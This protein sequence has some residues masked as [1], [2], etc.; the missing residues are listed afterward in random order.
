M[1]LDP[2]DEQLL[3]EALHLWEERSRKG[4]AIDPADLVPER[5]DLVEELSRRIEEVSMFNDMFG[6][7]IS[8]GIRE[9]EGTRIGPYRL[10]ENLG[11]G[12]FGVVFMADQE[13]PIRR[14]VAL[15]ILKDELNSTEV[16]ARFEAERHALALMEH[17]NIA[18]V[19]DAGATASGR[20]YFVM[21]LVK[22]IAIT[23]YCDLN[24]LTP[25]QRLELFVPVCQAIQHAHQKGVIHRD[26]KPSNVLVTLYDGKPVPKVIDFGVAKATDQRPTQ[27]A[28]LT[29]FGQIIGTPEYMSPEQAEMGKLDIDTRSDIYSL[30]VVLYEMLTGS[31]PLQTSSLREGSSTDIARRIR[32]DEPP[33]PSTR[34]SESKGALASIAAQ[35]MTEPAHLERLVRGELDWITMK[36]LAKDRTRR[37]E[38]ASGL[39]RDIERF[40]R[41]EPVE[42]GPPSATYVVRKFAHKHKA[43]LRT[44]AALG[45]VL[46]GAVALSSWLALRNPCRGYRGRAAR[47]S[48]AGS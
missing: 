40:L 31:T 41:D 38:S 22:G 24:R 43:A 42:A 28:K 7:T 34:L 25:R 12:S 10:L 16:I 5:A 1:S 19:L 18:K 37:Y 48:Q 13:N 27:R 9:L 46:L 36:A 2:R 11:E 20:P 29:Q 17:Q 30:G 21:E 3:G 4:N 15:K 6:D 23:E 32:E 35:R 39:A 45:L 26:I 44:V 14:Q 8:R 33:K 47:P